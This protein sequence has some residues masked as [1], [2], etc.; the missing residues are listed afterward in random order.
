MFFDS[1]QGALTA[2][3]FTTSVF[4]TTSNTAAD[5]LSRLER[6]V[7]SLWLMEVEGEWRTRALHIKGATAQQ[8]GGFNLDAS[9]GCTDTRHAAVPAFRTVGQ[10]KTDRTERTRKMKRKQYAAQFNVQVAILVSSGEKAAGRIRG[11]FDE[12]Q[13]MKT[14][15]VEAGRRVVRRRAKTTVEP[16]KTIDRLHQKIG[17]WQVE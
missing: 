9:Y 17:R 13:Q 7:Y 4:A 1:S 15:I 5:N 6:D 16:Q 3:I 8:D 14:G 12:D 10:A 2:L 11:A